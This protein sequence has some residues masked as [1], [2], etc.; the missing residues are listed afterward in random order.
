[1]RPAALHL[2]EESSVDPMMT[3]VYHESNDQKNWRGR[4]R[5]N[6]VDP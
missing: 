2:G 1:M 6:Q 4:C 5:L 3:G